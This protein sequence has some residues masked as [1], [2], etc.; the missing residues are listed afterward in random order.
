M[1]R[2]GSH[3]SRYTLR[4][5]GGPVL[6]VDIEADGEHGYARLAG[7]FGADAVAGLGRQLAALIDS[8]RRYLVVDFDRVQIVPP[9][10][11]CVLNRAAAGLRAVGGVLTVTG[12]PAPSIE[13]LRWAGLDDSIRLTVRDAH[14]PAAEHASDP[15]G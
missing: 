8:G 15:H 9:V 13:L 6:I 7:G 10:C 5:A 14:P 1:R 4:P 3:G 2:S 12:L 11:A